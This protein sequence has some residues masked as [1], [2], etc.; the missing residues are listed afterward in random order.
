MGR[1]VIQSLRGLLALENPSCTERDLL[2]KMQAVPVCKPGLVAPPGES[3]FVTV[4]G[5]GGAL[6]RLRTDQA[7]GWR[8]WPA[9]ESAMQAIERA[10]TVTTRALPL[11]FTPHTLETST[12]MSGYLVIRERED[13]WAPSAFDG[14]SLG[15][16]A[17]LAIAAKAMD[18][19]API[20]RV[21]VVA[22]GPNGELAPVDGLPIKLRVIADSALGAHQVLVHASQGP[23]ALTIARNLSRPLEIV[24]VATLPE[25]LAPL[26]ALARAQNAQASS[27]ELSR[28]TRRLWEAAMDTRRGIQAWGGVEGAARALLATERLSAEDAARASQVEAIARRHASG[29]G[30]LEA[31]ISSAHDTLPR[32]A[33]QSLRAQL[34]QDRTDSWLEAPHEQAHEWLAHDPTPELF[35]AAARAFGAVGLWEDAADHAMRAAQAQFDRGHPLEASRAVCEWLRVVAIQGRNDAVER[36]SRDHGARLLE[37]DVPHVTRAFVLVAMARANVLL[38]RSAEALERLREES[39]NLLD[40]LPTELLA[41]R[42][43]WLARALDDVGEHNEA[44]VVREELASGLPEESYFVALAELDRALRDGAE[45]APWLDAVRRSPLGYDLARV[46]RRCGPEA[47]EV[48]VARRLVRESLY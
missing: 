40:A 10:H 32:E 28:R 27:D 36:I 26:V 35:G 21:A 1:T 12:R 25:A 42:H 47:D 37:R 20:D 17:C 18:L 9:L 3:A 46:E 30:G 2:A 48:V 29:V 6:W 7:R 44:D 45:T 24:P 4:D 43:R 34:L 5:D 14:S 38:G 41:A 39:P 19:C 33:R 16:S 11:V 15:L 13:R 22:L 23:D 31:I 8:T